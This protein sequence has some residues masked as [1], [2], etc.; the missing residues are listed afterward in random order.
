[1][2][3]PNHFEGYLKVEEQEPFLSWITYPKFATQFK[4]QVQARGWLSKA[5]THF[6]TYRIIVRTI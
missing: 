6:P 4:S 1:M 5:K 3:G 2:Q